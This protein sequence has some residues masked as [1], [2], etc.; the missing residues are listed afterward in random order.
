MHILPNQI[1]PPNVMAVPGPWIFYGF[2]THPVPH[3]CSS[4]SKVY[5]VSCSS[6]NS[7]HINIISPMYW[8]H[9]TVVEKETYLGLASCNILWG[10]VG[11]LKEA[12]RRSIFIPSSEHKLILIIRNLYLSVF[13]LK[14]WRWSTFAGMNNI[15]KIYKKYKKFSITSYLAVFPM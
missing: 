6:G 12:F 8:A 7:S 5:K 14:L 13:S 15:L 10:W 11:S 4:S 1:T 2:T 3:R 9:F